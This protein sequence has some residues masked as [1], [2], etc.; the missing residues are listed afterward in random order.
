MEITSLVKDLRIKQIETFHILGDAAN[1][2]NFRDIPKKKKDFIL[3]LNRVFLRDNLSLDAHFFADRRFLYDVNYKLNLNLI[4]IRPFRDE[5]QGYRKEYVYRPV[6][7]IREFREDQEGTL[8]AGYS[9]LIPA[10]HFALLCNPKRII[11][12]GIQLKQNKHWYQNEGDFSTDS[13][14]YRR[15]IKAFPQRGK[16]CHAV[17]QLL[18]AFKYTQIY[19][20]SPD[21]LLVEYRIIKSLPDSKNF[22]QEA[23]NG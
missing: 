13:V 17:Q 3:G 18:F 16:I 5:L 20:S 4:G 2:I 12:S 10:L 15:M 21:N 8:L 7:E 1:I 11:L 9:V 22:W 6:W 19:S 14:A 23:S